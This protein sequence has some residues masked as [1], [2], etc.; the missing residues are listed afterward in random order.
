M[1]DTWKESP[2]TINKMEIFHYR[3]SQE[4]QYSEKT[5]FPNEQ[6]ELSLTHSQK[7]VDIF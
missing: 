6:F 5:G 2:W 7:I 3:I 4:M 1:S